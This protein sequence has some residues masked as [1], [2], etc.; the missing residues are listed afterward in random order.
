M[1]ILRRW[2]RQ[3]VHSARGATRFCSCY[4]IV[5]HD[6]YLELYGSTKLFYLRNKQGHTSSSA[7]TMTSLT[8]LAQQMCHWNWSLQKAH[9]CLV[10]IIQ[11]AVLHVKHHI[12]KTL[13]AQ[14][15]NTLFKCEYLTRISTA[16]T[17][18]VQWCF[19][20]DIGWVDS[21]FLVLEIEFNTFRLYIVYLIVEML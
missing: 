1:S 14:L 12:P 4:S 15:T 10:L 2:Q 21:K 7:T 13:T 19:C 8:V 20:F 18:W 16:Q 5:Y 9:G 17:V 3:Y 11:P 6:A